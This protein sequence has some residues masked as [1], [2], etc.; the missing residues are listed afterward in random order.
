MN[1][2]K[3]LLPL[4]YA[5]HELAIDCDAQYTTEEG[6]KWIRDNDGR[7]PNREQLDKLTK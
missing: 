2:L 5:A 7:Y 1:L 6:K 4:F 3:L